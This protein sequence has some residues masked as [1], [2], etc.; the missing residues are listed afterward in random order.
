MLSLTLLFANVHYPP[1]RTMPEPPCPS[2][3]GHICSCLS[4][5]FCRFNRHWNLFLENTQLVTVIPPQGKGYIL[6]KVGSLVHYVDPIDFI[7]I[8]EQSKRTVHGMR[9]NA[10]FFHPLAF[11]NSYLSSFRIGQNRAKHNRQIRCSK[12]SIIRWK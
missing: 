5:G 8:Q 6:C 2:S 3:H 4:A 7:W 11:Q 12:Y 10:P 1:L 9:K